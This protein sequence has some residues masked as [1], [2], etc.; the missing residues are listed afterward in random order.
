LNKKN[1]SVFIWH[2]APDMKSP[3]NYPFSA[4]VSVVGRMYDETK[5]I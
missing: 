3:E 4:S 5:V 1:E 2:T